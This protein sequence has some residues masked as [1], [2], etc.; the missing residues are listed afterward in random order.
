MKINKKNLEKEQ[1]K[2]ITKLQEN[3][4]IISLCVNILLDR[5]EQLSDYNIIWNKKL[6]YIGNNF[7][8]ELEEAEKI[9]WNHFT[10]EAQQENFF[11]VAAYMD[12]TLE[13]IANFNGEQ[14]MLLLRVAEL[15]EKKNEIKNED[16]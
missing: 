10:K 3:L 4:M 7:K 12:K 2:I 5:L 11:A 16:F 15:I 9:V 8:K 13:K 6:K 14:L 1:E